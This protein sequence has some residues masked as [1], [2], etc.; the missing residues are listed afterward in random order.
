MPDLKTKV[1][2]LTEGN[3]YVFRVAAENKAGIGPFSEP[4]K[5]ITT[6][7]PYEKPGKPGRPK[8]SN[9]KGFTL[10]LEW[11]APDSDGGMYITTFLILCTMTLSKRQ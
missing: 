6:K 1:E 11:K 8:T 7:S 2:E 9:F 10:D 4:S 5:P 3:E